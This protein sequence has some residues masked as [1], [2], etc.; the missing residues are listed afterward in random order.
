M[1]TKCDKNEVVHHRA[2]P[3]IAFVFTIVFTLV[4]TVAAAESAAPGAAPEAASVSEQKN[5]QYCT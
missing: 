3:K 2:K 4:A 1:H 5:L